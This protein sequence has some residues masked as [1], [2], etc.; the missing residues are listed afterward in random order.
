[1]TRASPDFKTLD[2][3]TI[4]LS[5]HPFFYNNVEM[6]SHVKS[7]S[8]NSAQY[9]IY[10]YIYIYIEFLKMT[11]KLDRFPLLF[12]LQIIIFLTDMSIS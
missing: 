3:I 12:N 6:Q 5:F 2:L 8:L 9:Y 7:P 1:M 10:I 11:Y 4:I